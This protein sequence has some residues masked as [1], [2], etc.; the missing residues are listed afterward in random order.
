VSKAEPDA[1]HYVREYGMRIT[2]EVDRVW[3][4]GHSSSISLETGRGGGDCGYEFVLGQ[5]YLVYVESDVYFGDTHICTRTKPLAAAGSE[6]R[7][8]SRV[9]VSGGRPNSSLHRTRIRTLPSR[10]ASQPACGSAPGR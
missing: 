3:K 10:V 6:V 1:K 7:E 5:R 9:A 8:L 4:G 2:F